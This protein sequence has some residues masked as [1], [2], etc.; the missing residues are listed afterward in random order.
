VT[1]G[2]RRRS[3]LIAAGV[4]LAA[5][6]V[7][8]ALWLGGVGGGA[9]PSRAPSAS[10]KAPAPGEP[11][12]ASLAARPV[13]GAPGSTFEPW[14]PADTSVSPDDFVGAETC[15]E[16]HAREYDVWKRSTHG[17][18]GAA[19]PRPED[20]V[21]PFDGVAMRFADATVIP[22]RARDGRYRFRIRRPGRPEDTLR[23]DG[24]VGKGHMKGGG[25]QGSLL[26]EA[27]GTWRFLPFDFSVTGGRWF[28]NTEGRATQGGWVPVTPELPLEACLDWTPRRVLGQVGRY[29]NC[30]ECHGS[31]IHVTVRRGPPHF[32]TRFTSLRINCESCHGPGR[33]HVELARAGR[34]P[35]ARDIGIAS[36]VG[37]DRDASLGVCMQCHAFKDALA[38]GYLPGRSLSAH[39]SLLSPE[40]GE[41]PLYPDGRVRTF[42]YQLDHIS[43]ACYLQ[44]GMTCVDCHDP[45][46]QTYR[47]VEGAP[48]NGRFDDGQCLDCHPAKAEHPERH[49]H[50]PAGSPGSQCVACHMPYLQEMEIGDQIPYG[51]SDHTIPVPRPLADSAE[52]VEPS[53]SGCHADRTATELEADVRRWWGEPK[54]RRPLVATLFGADTLGSLATAGPELVRPGSPDPLARY[55]GLATVVDRYLRPGIPLPGAV[56]DSLE[57]MVRVGDLDARSLAL[58]AL[59]LSA[60]ADTVSGAGLARLAGLD[61]ALRSRVLARWAQAL[62]WV[63]DRYRDR[64]SSDS[65]EAVYRMA[66]RVAPDDPDL[67]AGLAYAYL[68]GGDPESALREYRSALQRK[69]DDAL[70]LVNAGIALLRLGR[71]EEATSAYREALAVDPSEPLARFNLANAHLR[72]GDLDS[73]I[74]EYRKTI[75]LDASLAPAHF[76]LARA[77]LASRRYEP[78]LRA[79]E[80]GLAYDSTNREAREAVRQL[81]QALGGR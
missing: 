48:L 75:Q 3:L 14:S 22:E 32:D 31:Q 62:G 1:A 23:I 42:A 45:H 46:S 76:N 2:A 21:A 10:D 16:C 36:L 74:A 44:G 67:R 40:L 71:T 69:P 81:R 72:A 26:Q 4:L 73:A 79:L 29:T 8:G 52:G 30:Q 70:L 38:P 51:R 15:G 80:D 27:D 58:A 34:I 49:T 43:S 56:R 64:G 37:L 9:A 12:P 41:S 11:G 39:Y 53:C 18:A 47:T 7:A 55:R 50:H 20:V 33:R 25:T 17:T 6:A 5:G 57:L 59:D 24:V 54:P 78:A 66:L 35:G 13:P 68:S 65:A 60:G 19:R 77:Y 28:C 61:P 63:A